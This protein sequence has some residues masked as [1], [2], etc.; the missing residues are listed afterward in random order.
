MFAAM[1]SQRSALSAPAI[2]RRVTPRVIKPRKV[3]RPPR[4]IT[5]AILKASLDDRVIV[6]KIQERAVDRG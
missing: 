4:L 1:I 2:V 3:I 5:A 6:R